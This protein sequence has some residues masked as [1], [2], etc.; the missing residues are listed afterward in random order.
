LEHVTTITPSFAD[1]FFRVLFE[2][3][4]EERYRKCVRVT[5]ASDYVKRLI[6]LVLKNR[7][8]LRGR[9]E[10]VPR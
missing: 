9:A 3:I 4:G 1:E 10:W 8:S 7:P 5:G 2:E 6:E